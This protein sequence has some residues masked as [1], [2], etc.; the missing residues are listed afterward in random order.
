[1]NPK[2]IHSATDLGHQ[3]DL[4]RIDTITAFIMVGPEGEGIPA[5]SAAGMM[6]PMVGADH[7]RIAQLR[8]YAVEMAK[9]EGKRIKLVRFSVREEIEI[10]EP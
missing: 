7:A 6:M 3:P 9:R 1:M 10:I 2:D 8:P 4:P 5:F